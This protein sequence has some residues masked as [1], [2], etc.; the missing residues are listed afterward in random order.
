MILYGEIGSSGLASAHKQL[1]ELAREGRVKY[2]LRHFVDRELDSL[3]RLSGYGVELQ[4]KS[5]EYKAQDDAELRGEGGEGEEDEE[6]GEVEGFVFSTLKALHEDKV[7][8]LAEMKQHLLDMNN[9]M[10]PMKVC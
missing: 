4:I 10:A 6:E 3:V 8:K 1:S 2:I 7:D 5:T 9:D